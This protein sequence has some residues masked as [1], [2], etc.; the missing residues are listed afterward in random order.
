MSTTPES[1]AKQAAALEAKPPLVVAAPAVV[2]EKTPPK[3]TAVE[4]P[5]KTS[6]CE[7]CG[8][9][10]E[11][12]DDKHVCVDC[13]KY[14]NRKSDNKR[15]LQFAVTVF[16]ATQAAL[17]AWLYSLLEVAAISVEG[18]VLLAVFF[19]SV[20]VGGIS[21]L[22]S[23]WGKDTKTLE[24]SVAELQHKLDLVNQKAILT[25]AFNA[26]LVERFADKK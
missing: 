15:A 4:P 6:T 18:K 24:E 3:A 21:E 25:E 2:D 17:L 10:F 11:Q 1:V 12:Y 23:I 20:V 19:S 9:T 13:V 14:Y 16:A 8:G 5:K 26:T 7:L 22:A